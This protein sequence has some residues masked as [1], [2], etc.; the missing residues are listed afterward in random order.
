M[1]AIN[2]CGGVSIRL[3]PDQIS[4]IVE[5]AT[6]GASVASLRFLQGRMRKRGGVNRRAFYHDKRLSQSMLQGL[7][8]LCMF[9]DGREHTIAKVAAEL[10]I[11]T[12][13]A[14]RLARTWTAVQVLELDADSGSYRLASSRQEA[15]GR[16]PG[17]SRSRDRKRDE[18]GQTQTN[19]QVA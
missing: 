19:K 10:H 9:A 3:T 18:D 15:A 4:Q 8:V 7:L 12:S 17:T 1:A 11:P 14:Y 13:T 2:E 16:A 5:E 6:A